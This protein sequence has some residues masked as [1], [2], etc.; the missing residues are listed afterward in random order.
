MKTIAKEWG[1][2]FFQQKMW[3]WPYIYIDEKKLDHP[4]S[5]YIYIHIDKLTL[6]S[7]KIDKKDK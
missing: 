1:K 3:G 6:N 4:V 7:P 2:K 5:A